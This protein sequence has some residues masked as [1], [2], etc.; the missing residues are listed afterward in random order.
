MDTKIQLQHAQNELRDLLNKFKEIPKRAITENRNMTSAEVSKFEDI[1]ADVK[2]KEHEI[3]KL[4]E[5]MEIEKRQASGEAETVVATIPGAYGKNVKDVS[6]RQLILKQSQGRKFSENEMELLKLGAEEAKLFGADGAGIAIPSSFIQKANYSTTTPAGTIFTGVHDTIDVD[7]E[8][9]LL[10]RIGVTQ[11]KI[12]GGEYN[13]NF[14]SGAT[15]GFV[16]EG[17]DFGD[18]APTLASDKVTP[19]RCGSQFSYNVE[20][21]ASSIREAEKEVVNDLVG[22]IDRGA[23]N[24]LLTTLKV[25]TSV[26]HSSYEAADTATVPASS[27]LFTL[28]G[29]LTGVRSYIK[30]KFVMS[31][32][33]FYLIAQTG[34]MASSVETPMIGPDG[35]FFRWDCLETEYLPVHTSTKYDI[36][37]GDWAKSYVT[38][39]GP[40][41]LI[42]DGITQ[43]KKGQVIVTSYRLADISYN[44][45]KFVAGRNFDLS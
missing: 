36:I 9:G 37:F 17:G 35:K 34:Y 44:P 15:A 22:A 43:A 6:L 27:D 19:R 45:A 23:A 29:S 18:G 31:K 10:D 24:E 14:S 28:A 12:P 25:D 42:V 11:I 32:E 13:L 7:A 39:F 33:L 21:L 40:V 41:M 3:T 20:W 38:W 8:M 4:K 26:I 16:S 5:K 2:I 1:E 30:P